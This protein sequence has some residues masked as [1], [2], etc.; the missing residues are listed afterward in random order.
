MPS[1]GQK[2]FCRLV[3]LTCFDPTV[4]SMSFTLAGISIRDLRTERGL[5]E[6]RTRNCA[7]WCRRVAV[8]FRTIRMVWWTGEACL[9]KACRAVRSRHARGDRFR[10]VASKPEWLT[11][12]QVGPQ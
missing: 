2:G 9:H 10:L 11:S 8:C 12:D 5:A 3:R 6:E 7:G 4:S 1:W